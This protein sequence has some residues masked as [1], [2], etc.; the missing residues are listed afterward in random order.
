MRL[1]RGWYQRSTAAV[2]VGLLGCEVRCG[3]VHVRVTEVEAYAGPEDS[4][5]HAR[6]DRQ[7]RSKTMFGPAGRAYVYLCYGVHQMLNVVAHEPGEAGAVLIRSCELIRGHGLVARRRGAAVLR[8]KEAAWLK[9]PG[10]VG[11][12]LGIDRA[13]DGHPLYRAG[14]LTIHEGE[15]PS[16]IG[17]GR[18]VGIDFASPGARR[19]RWRFACAHTQDVTAPKE[20]RVMSRAR[21][22]STLVTPRDEGRSR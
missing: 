21:A 6:F 8:L 5:S 3:A 12:G 20:L 2:A 4:A 13:W 19:R 10:N 7:G 17:V 11:K 1:A 18:R 14:G 22:L 15:A 9:G 16:K